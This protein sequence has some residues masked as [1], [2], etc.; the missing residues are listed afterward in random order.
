MLPSAILEERSN[1]RGLMRRP[2]FEVSIRSIFTAFKLA[3]VLLIGSASKQRSILPASYLMVALPI[4]A[5]AVLRI[6]LGLLVDRVGAK[7]AG[8]MAQIVVMIGLELA[9]IFGLLYYPATL[10]ANGLRAGC[11]QCKL[12]GCLAASR[13]PISAKD[14][15]KVL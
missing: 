12:R 2:L 6:L 15:C 10:L 9:W 8:I 7:N 4:L 5:G 11:R 3:G 13:T 1:R 14:A